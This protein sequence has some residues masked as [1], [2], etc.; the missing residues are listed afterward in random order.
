MGKA[1]AVSIGTEAGVRLLSAGALGSPEFPLL[2]KLLFPSEE[3][4]ALSCEQCV[5]G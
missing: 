4:C 5:L 3:L 1:R 2:V